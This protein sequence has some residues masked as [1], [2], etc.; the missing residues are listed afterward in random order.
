[1]TASWTVRGLLGLFLI[2]LLATP[3]VIKQMSARHAT[4]SSSDNKAEAFTRYGF[5]LE[6]SAAQARPR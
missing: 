4:G 2:A 1:M 6:E 3:L 5:R